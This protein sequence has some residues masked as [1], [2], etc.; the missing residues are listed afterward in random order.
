M[1]KKEE[2]PIL[3]IF[4]TKR[5]ITDKDGDFIVHRLISDSKLTTRDAILSNRK[6]KALGLLIC[7]IL[8]LFLT[9][10]VLALGI[11]SIKSIN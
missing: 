9:I 3:D 4:E 1:T 5:V 2:Y 11:S 10:A 8:F 6:W 7:L